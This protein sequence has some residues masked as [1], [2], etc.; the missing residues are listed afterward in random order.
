MISFFKKQEK[1]DFKM[2]A[3]L[4]RAEQKEIRE[5]IKNAQ[6]NDG[7]TMQS[8]QLKH[9]GRQMLKHFL[10]GKRKYCS[11]QLQGLSRVYQLLANI[12]KLLQ[13]SVA[14]GKPIRLKGNI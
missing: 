3:N 2:P 4:T 11:L 1:R 6:K 8:S 10:K 12:R 7:I 13:K 14:L 9:L 5:I